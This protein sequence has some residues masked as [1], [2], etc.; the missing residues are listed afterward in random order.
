MTA[1]MLTPSYKV[2]VVHNGYKYDM[3]QVVT[4]LSLEEQENTLAQKVT[5]GLVQRPHGSHYT[6]TFISVRDTV[7]IY[8]KTGT[9]YHEIFRGYIWEETYTK[10][11]D[12]ELRITCYDRMI[13]LQESEEYMYFPK[14]KSTASIFKEICKRKGIKCSYSHA[15]VTHS[16]LAIRGTLGD[17]F[18]DD[19]IDEV[20][21][22][23]GKI[24][25]IRASKGEIKIFTLGKGNSTVYK[26]SRSYSKSNGN[27]TSIKVT[28]SLDGLVTKVIILGQEKDK[29]RAPIRATVKGN[30]SKYGT[31][32][33]IETSSKNDKLAT[34]K[35]EAQ[36]TIKD[37]GK[38]TRS[39]E[40]TAVNNPFVRKGDK[41]YVDDTYIRKGY[42]YVR[43]VSH[44]AMKGLMTM[45]VTLA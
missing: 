32:Q 27:I 41:I 9:S 5:I 35:K 10:D 45:E 28:Y 8:A 42:C 25:V 22:R 16:K 2:Y 11:A 15:S 1:S 23:T 40:I 36:Q 13:Y 24:G 44:D 6:S 21:K 37:K 38:P 17:V 4:Q 31:I 20:R 19:L 18:T 33:K 34:L 14:G 3:S 26:F 39:I 30:T 29:K 12:F 7:Y 43:S